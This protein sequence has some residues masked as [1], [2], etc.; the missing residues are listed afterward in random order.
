[1]VLQCAVRALT[2]LAANIG[3]GLRFY[4]EVFAFRQAPRANTLTC[5]LGHFHLRLRQPVPS[6]AEQGGGGDGAVGSSP[7]PSLTFPLLTVAVSNIT[8]SRGLV[9]R[10]G[11]QLGH[12][13]LSA[14]SQRHAQ[15]FGITEPSSVCLLTGPEGVSAV[16]LHKFKRNPM[17]AVTLVCSDVQAS[18]GTTRALAPTAAAAVRWPATCV[19]LLSGCSVSSTLPRMLCSRVCACVL[20]CVCMWVC[21]CVYVCMCDV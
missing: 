5:G 16:A 18:A 1:M 4:T 2:I 21:M 17:L 6:E 9:T 20:V 19:P 14:W 11:G 10:R 8:R 12:D 7:P 15:S 13:S 3:D